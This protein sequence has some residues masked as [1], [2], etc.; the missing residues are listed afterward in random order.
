MALIHGWGWDIKRA[1]P[2][3]DL[4]FSMFSCCFS[5]VETRQSTV[6]S[7]I[8]APRTVDWQPHL[9]SALQNKPQSADGPLQDRSVANVKFIASI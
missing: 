7:L 8:E 5:F 1:P 3:L 6:V 4:G 2:D 9:V